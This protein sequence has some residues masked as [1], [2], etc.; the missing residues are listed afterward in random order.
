M[1]ESIRIGVIGVGHLGRYHAQKYAAMQGVKL[2]GVADLNPA[3]AARAARE[4]GA[5]AFTDY[6][7]LV[8]KVDAVS[9]A[10]T[11]TSHFEV[12]SFCLQNGMDVMMEKPITTTLAEADTL[13]RLAADHGRILQV[14]LIERFNPAIR[15][16]QPSLNLPL[17]I[18]AKRVSVFTHRSTDVDV[19]ID[20]MIH[21]LDIILSL[22]QAPIASLSAVGG[23]IITPHTDIVNAHLI[24]Q[25]GCTANITTSRVSPM[26]ER[27]MRIFQPGECLTIDFNQKSC[28][29]L[30][31]T[32]DALENMPV[33]VVREIPVVPADALEQE[34]LDFVG[35]VRT[36]RQPTVTGAQGRDALALALEIIAAAQKNHQLLNQTM[37]A[38]GFRD[39]AFLQHATIRP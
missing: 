34:L 36:R 4:T 11:T 33:P 30:K 39:C 38:A 28:S 8:G 13:V 37:Q 23:P 18:E 6:R 32:V 27:R 14:G 5:A 24:F 17:F 20:L 1:T 29:Q 12:G 21:D 10:T 35:C 25:N 2:V 9:V 16:I 26:M 31:L 3:Q 7:E 19:I 15:A 22:V